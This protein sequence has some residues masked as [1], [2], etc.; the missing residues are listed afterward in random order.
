[1]VVVETDKVYEAHSLPTRHPQQRSHT[2]YSFS[3]PSLAPYDNSLIQSLLDIDR[4]T[5]LPQY[6]SHLHNPFISSI[7]ARKYKG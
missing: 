2:N 1:M 3:T 7:P 5:N 4:N 6:I